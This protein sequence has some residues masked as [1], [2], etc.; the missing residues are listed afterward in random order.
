MVTSRAGRERGFPLS[1]K[2]FP[3]DRDGRPRRFSRRELAEALLSGLAAGLV[4]PLFPARHPVW[5]LLLDGEV[6][7]SAEGRLSSDLAKGSFLSGPQLASL[8]MLAEA[9]IPGSRQTLA[10]QFIDLLLSVDSRKHQQ[11]FLRS[12][13]ALEEASRRATRRDIASLNPAELHD[14]LVEVSSPQSPVEKDFL[15]LRSWI[16]GA[17]YSSE[18]GM[19]ELGWTPD[20]VFSSFPSCGHVEGHS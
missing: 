18:T 7:D 9:I 12:A 4:A 14:L 15:N 2:D 1:V 19:R 11:E 5:R 3:V 8:A 6:L 17:Y 20:R 16:A 13:A 10:P